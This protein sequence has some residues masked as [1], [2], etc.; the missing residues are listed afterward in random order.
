[1]HHTEMGWEDM[2]WIYDTQDGASGSSGEYWKFL[3]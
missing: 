3:D 2:D 1:M